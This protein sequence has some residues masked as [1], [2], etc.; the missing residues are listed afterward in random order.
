MKTPLI[1][2]LFLM[3]LSSCFT[4]NNVYYSDPNYLGSEEF[5]AYDDIIKT[6]EDETT[7]LDTGSIDNDYYGDYYEAG[8]YYDYSYSSRLR[9]F[10]RPIYYS[11]YYGGIYTDYYWYNHDPF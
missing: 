1:S 8:D 4:T 2:I 9:R 5:S 11:N 10:H 6:T 7:I 3:I